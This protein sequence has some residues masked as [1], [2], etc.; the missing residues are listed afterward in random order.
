[1]PPPADRPRPGTDG[2]KGAAPS[3]LRTRELQIKTPQ[4]DF[5]LTCP[6]L[7]KNTSFFRRSR[8]KD[9]WRF[10]TSPA[11]SCAWAVSYAWAR[12]L[13]HHFY[14]LHPARVVN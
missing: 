14:D 9:A 5:V 7:T 3:V 11:R 10:A 12:F 6:I 1:M 4:H 2:A 8:P 13:P